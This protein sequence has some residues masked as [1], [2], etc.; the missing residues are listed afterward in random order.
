MAAI[1]IDKSLFTPDELAQ[2]EAL[3]AKAIV[4]PE[5]NEEEMEEDIPP[6]LSRRAAPEPEEEE[7]VEAEKR[8]ARKSADPLAKALELATAR[9]DAL[10]KSNET[11]ELAEVAKKYSVLGEDEKELTETLYA[12]KKS[13]PENYEAYI[14][15][16][17][18][19]L[20]LMQKSGLFSEIGKSGRGVRGSAEDRIEKAAS[21][22][23]KADPSLTR[24]EAI[25]KAWDAN[26]DLLAEY[27]R[28]Y[29]Q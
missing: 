25:V 28:E 21:D 4:N 5:E 2:Y 20:D 29:R 18:K 7:E 8:S 16:L 22:M 3:L 23:Q 14:K 1:K 11:R 19:S 10:E 15:V 13:S 27:E 24:E 9:L 12:L 26:P 6:A 17:D